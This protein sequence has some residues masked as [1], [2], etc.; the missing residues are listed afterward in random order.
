MRFSKSAIWATATTAVFVASSLFGKAE[1]SHALNRRQ[2]TPCVIGAHEMAAE[3]PWVPP[4]AKACVR[5]LKTGLD[6]W[7]SELCTAAAIMFGVQQINDLSN[8]YTD[9]APVPLPAEQPDLPQ[10]I[11]ASIVGDCAAQGCP[12]SL[13]NFVDFIYG[14]IKAQ[15]LTSYPDSVDTLENFYIQPIFTF[16]G[17]TLEE[18]VPYDAFNQWLHISGFTN[19]YVSP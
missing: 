10:E 17:Y 19:H 7:E 11:Y 8:C 4:M 6:F 15:G 16:G 9:L 1:A 12:I 2:N 18:G 14:Q 5:Q 13:L 3:R